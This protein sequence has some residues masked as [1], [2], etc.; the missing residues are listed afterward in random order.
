MAEVDG[1]FLCRVQGKGESM[2]PHPQPPSPAPEL[3]DVTLARAQRGEGGAFELLVRH[4]QGTVWSFLWRMLGLAASRALV[5]DL[6]QE[7]FLGVHRGLARFTTD[8]PARLSTWI[9]TIATRVVLS[10]RR[11]LRRQPPVES[12]SVEADDGGAQASALE[13]RV[14]VVALVRALEGLTPQHR[15]IFVLREFH[16]LEYEEIARVLALEIG[17]VRSR[18]HRAR[19]GLRRA[20]EEE[21]S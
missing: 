4:Y 17:T 1:T 19:E 9:L 2:H 10:R 13:R 6:F 20:L 16:G 21:K 11:R 15:A 5:E 8:G 12:A 3:D 14:L 7:T 18:L